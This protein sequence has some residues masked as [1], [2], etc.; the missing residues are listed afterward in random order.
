MIRTVCKN[1]LLDGAD[2]AIEHD[3]RPNKKKMSNK[4]QWC[5]LD[6]GD[7]GW[8]SATCDLIGT[9]KPQ[10]ALFANTQQLN[11]SLKRVCI[12]IRIHIYTCLNG[13]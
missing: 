11:G 1:F 10:K 13:L 12:Y 7:S 9:L 8:K 4:R 6:D 5:L 3:F 2:S